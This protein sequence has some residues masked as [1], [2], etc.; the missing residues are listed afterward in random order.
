MPQPPMGSLAQKTG[1]RLARALWPALFIYVG[2]V[3]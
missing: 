3:V 2:I 1:R